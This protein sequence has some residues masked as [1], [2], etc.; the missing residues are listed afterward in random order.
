LATRDHGDG[1]RLRAKDNAVEGDTTLSITHELKS[2]PEFFNPVFTG[3]KNF[4]LRKNDRNF[5]VGDVIV[6]REWQ[7]AKGFEDGG[8]YT[9]RECRRRISYI[10]EGLG[11]GAMQGVI[12]P[13]WGLDRGYV[14][15]GLMDTTQ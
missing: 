5:V 6:L 7:P 10:L 4:E 12:K 9:G 15:L 13:Y 8:V 2:W 1:T 14:I 3:I 11:V